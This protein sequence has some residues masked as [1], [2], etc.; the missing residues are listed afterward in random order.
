MRK[1]IQLIN[2]CSYTKLVNSLRAYTKYEILSHVCID[3]LNFCAL[4]S[5][6]VLTSH[7]D[8]THCTLKV[9]KHSFLLM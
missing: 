4:V 3:F 5:I 6:V 8:H 1:F 9:L 2:V 7:N